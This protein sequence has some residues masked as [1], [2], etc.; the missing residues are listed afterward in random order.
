MLS[1]P[2]P[3]GAVGGVGGGETTTNGARAEERAVVVVVVTDFVEEDAL[4]VIRMEELFVFLAES[5]GEWPEESVE[6]DAWA[7]EAVLGRPKDVVWVTASFDVFESP[8]D[9]RAADPSE[10][11]FV[12]RWTWL[13]LELDEDVRMASAERVGAASVVEPAN[14]GSSTTT[15]STTVSTTAWT[16]GMT[17]S[18]FARLSAAHTSHFHSSRCVRPYTRSSER[19]Q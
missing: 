5:R 2:A 10:G 18:C 16:T 4:A 14:V 7:K 15:V 19:G 12:V 1:P 3:V 13:A 17:C 8:T 9:V 6:G 11:A